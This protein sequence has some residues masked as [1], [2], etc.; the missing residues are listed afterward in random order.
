MHTLATAYAS[1][2]CNIDLGYLAR[3]LGSNPGNVFS[4]LTELVTTLN[5]LLKG[6]VKRRLVS[7]GVACTDDRVQFRK[8]VFDSSVITQQ[9][10]CVFILSH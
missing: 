7:A 6:D 9:R 4:L 2:N 10:T 3:S 5:A 1:P 8:G